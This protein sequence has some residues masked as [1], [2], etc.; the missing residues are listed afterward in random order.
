MENRGKIIV[1]DFFRGKSSS[2]LSDVG[3]FV[4]FICIKKE[5]STMNLENLD[6]LSQKI[7]SMLEALRRLKNEKAEAEK[8]VA[9]KSAELEDLRTAMSEK[10]RQIE[11]LQ[12]ELASKESEAEALRK[13]VAE[14]DAELESTKATLSEREAKLADMDKVVSE[15]G[16]EIQNAQ[17][18]FQNLLSTIESELGTEIPVQ[19]PGE[20]SQASEEQPNGSAG[21]SAQ[22]DFFG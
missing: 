16:N 14:R 15:Q 1:R 12:G 3:N 7:E 4:Y 5:F 8:S 6:L 11:A 13:T 20:E 21:E 2:C 17:E 9:A 22:A 10:S 19:S 18:K